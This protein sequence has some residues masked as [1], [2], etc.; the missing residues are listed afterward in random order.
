MSVVSTNKFVSTLYFRTDTE[1][2][3]Y[4]SLAGGNGFSLV[5]TD[6]NIE[7]L[8]VTDSDWDTSDLS[9]LP[10]YDTTPPLS[11]AIWSDEL[12]LYDNR[13]WNFKK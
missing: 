5:S 6:T 8:V 4:S 7:E 9:W 1:A 13:A 10:R 12:G 3:E 2:T 11:T